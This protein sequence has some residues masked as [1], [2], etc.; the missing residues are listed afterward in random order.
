MKRGVWIVE[1]RLFASRT[2][3]IFHRYEGMA[4]FST[5]GGA[6]AF[7]DSYN[8]PAG[9]YEYRAVHYVPAETK[10]AKQKARLRV[11]RF[12]CMTC[13]KDVCSCP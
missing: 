1:R 4:A 9:P 11:S 2:W 6:I 10:P 12:A 5:R 3:R 8:D 7:C 13:R